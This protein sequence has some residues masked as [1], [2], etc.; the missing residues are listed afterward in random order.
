MV[1]IN[2]NE[3]TKTELEKKLDTISEN[4]PKSQWKYIHRGSLYNFVFNLELIQ[5]TSER[6]KTLDIL[7][8]Y[9]NDVELNFE[10][11]IDYS[12]YLFNNYLK[13]IVPIYRNHLGFSAVPSKYALIVLSISLI[14]IFILLMKS[15]LWELL[16]CFLILLISFKDI[17]NFRR[18]KVYGF[19][20]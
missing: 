14:A 5:D 3:M 13:Y 16:Y 1:N 4:I 18:H 20:Y 11:E 12:I 15:P 2:K 8:N 9:L 7:F 6:E 19:R 17:R 10:P